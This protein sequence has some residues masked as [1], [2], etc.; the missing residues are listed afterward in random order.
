MGQN[1]HVVDRVV[2][3]GLPAWLLQCRES[4]DYSDAFNANMRTTLMSQAARD[5]AAM[6]L[7]HAANQAAQDTAHRVIQRPSLPPPHSDPP[8]HHSSG[9][10]PC[11]D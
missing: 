3:L 2:G 10:F 8:S 6:I 5:D 1:Q 4:S 9:P 11:R 7:G